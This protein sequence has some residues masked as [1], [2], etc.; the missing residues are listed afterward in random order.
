MMKKT[1]RGFVREEKDE[2]EDCYYKSVAGH[3]VGHR[4][5]EH[6]TRSAARPGEHSHSSGS[7][8]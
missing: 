7:P 2:V 5:R 6:R 3:E 1:D 4:A 8:K